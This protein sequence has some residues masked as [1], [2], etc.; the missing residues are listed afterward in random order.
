[1]TLFLTHD[2]TLLTNLLLYA[3]IHVSLFLFS[4]LSYP[5]SNKMINNQSGREPLNV[6]KRVFWDT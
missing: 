4:P 5:L 1:M 2:A 6:E 3:K